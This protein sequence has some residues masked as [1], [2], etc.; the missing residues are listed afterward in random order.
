[1]L[2]NQTLAIP[3]FILLGYLLGSIPSAVWIG[4]QFFG[5]DVRQFGSG[6]AGATNTFR[7]LGTKAGIIVLLADIIKGFLAVSIPI[8]SHI[9]FGYDGGISDLGMV[10]GISSVLGHLYPVFARFKG[11]KGVATGL[12]IMLAAAPFASLASVAVF[13]LIWLGSSYVSLASLL[14]ALSFPFFLFLLFYPEGNILKIAAILLPLIIAYTHRGNI[15]KLM[16]GTENKTSPFAKK[17]P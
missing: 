6:N 7:V 17:E 16:N 11:G 15:I 1:M 10:C 5:K 9:G 3:F 13:V 14:G 12:G 4:K 8:W 2:E